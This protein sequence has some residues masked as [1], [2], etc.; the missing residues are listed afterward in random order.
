MVSAVVLV[1]V[2]HI[3]T[4]GEGG[5][6][7]RAASASLV[8]FFPPAGLQALQKAAA[9]ALRTVVPSLRSRVPVARLVDRVDQAHPYPYLH[10][11]PGGGEGSDRRALRRLGIRT[12]T[13]MEEAVRSC[14]GSSPP[15]APLPS[16]V[17]KGRAN[18]PGSPWPRTRLC[19]ARGPGRG[20]N[21]LVSLADRG[22]SVT[23]APRR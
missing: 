21:Y 15:S 8:G 11:A 13:A 20:R 5:A 6:G 17:E 1:L 14:A 10:L 18:P 4:P 19:R 23:C 7:A 22:D 16:I 3:A 9:L 2:F 12:A